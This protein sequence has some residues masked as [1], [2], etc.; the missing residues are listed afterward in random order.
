MKKWAF[1]LACCLLTGCA[2]HAPA[3]SSKVMIDY[4]KS[5]E[6][7]YSQT[8]TSMKALRVQKDQVY[9]GN[10]VLINK[11]HEVHPE[12]IQTDIVSL[13]NHQELI[14]GFGLLD[15]TIELSQ[16]VV[17]QFGKMVAAAAK[18]DVNHFVISSGYRDFAKQEQLYKEKGSDYALPAG[19]SEHNLGLALDI[20]SSLESMD[21]APEGKWLKEHAADYG[22]IL[23]YP[24]DKTDITGIQYEPWHFRYVGLPHSKIMQ[25]NNLTLEEYLDWLHEHNTV[26]VNVDGQRYE[27]TYKEVRRETAFQIPANHTYELSGD[28][29]E[30]VIATIKL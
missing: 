19:N 12:G 7:T 14:N 18:D 28:N 21:Q 3:A 30:W 8:D 26:Y 13:L 29:Q 25:S 20:G 22:F 27:I 2:K 4:P 15:N 9:Q 23:R 10:L 11:D 16:N 17:E 5:E 1:V 24:A 6:I